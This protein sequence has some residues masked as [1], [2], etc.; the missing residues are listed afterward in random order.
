MENTKTIATNKK[1]YHEYFVIESFEA[2]ISLSGTEVK[3]IRQGKVNLSDGFATISFNNTT[4]VSQGIKTDL[5]LDNLGLVYRYLYPQH[6]LRIL[7]AFMAIVGLLQL[8]II[9]TINNIKTIDLIED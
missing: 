6:L 1:A 3:S 9:F 2:G 8:P 7:A 4:L 5:V